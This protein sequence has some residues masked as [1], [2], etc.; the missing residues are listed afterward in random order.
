M[1]HNHC[2]SGTRIGEPCVYS[3]SMDQPYPR[4]CEYCQ[5]PAPE[6]RPT[7]E[8]PEPNCTSGPKC[9]K[10]HEW[11]P[12]TQCCIWC[13]TY[14]PIDK[15]EPTDTKH[16]VIR[17]GKAICDGCMAELEIQL[18]VQVE[19]WCA[20]V[21]SFVETH[22]D[23]GRNILPWPK[24][25]LTVKQIEEMGIEVGDVIEGDEGIPPITTRLKL[26]WAGKEIVVWQ[27]FVQQRGSNRFV[28]QGERSNWTLNSRRWRRRVE[29]NETPIIEGGA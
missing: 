14:R 5:A 28:N 29:Q 24:S 22:K 1:N 7:P 9:G 25:S 2:K 15:V 3:K 23:H 20:A 10:P 19:D 8:T 26:I 21:L 4:L 6:Y 18:P 27:V 16:V 12:I 13:G 11:D 17:N